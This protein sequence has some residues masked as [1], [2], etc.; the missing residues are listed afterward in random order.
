M[1]VTTLISFA[2]VG[3]VSTAMD[4]LFLNASRRTGSPVWLATALGFLSGTCTGFFLNSHYVFQTSLTVFRY[5]KYLMVS[6]GGL[7]ITECIMYLFH[8]RWK[9]CGL[10]QAKCVAV[11]VVFFWNYSLSVLWAFD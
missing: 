9:F 10:N 3:A 5:E 6:F 7:V 11:A 4:F 1:Q 8:Q 2:A